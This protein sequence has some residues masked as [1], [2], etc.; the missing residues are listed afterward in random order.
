MIALQQITKRFVHTYVK[1]RKTLINSFLRRV[2]PISS[3]RDERGFAH[4]NPELVQYGGARF[5]F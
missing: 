5:Y 2:N 1:R 3:G 4:Q